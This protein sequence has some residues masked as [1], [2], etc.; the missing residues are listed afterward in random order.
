[1]E[2][3]FSTLVAISIYI[4]L[5]VII[6]ASINDFTSAAIACYSTLFPVAAATYVYLHWIR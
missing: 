5:R 2:I 3:I 4:I 6:Y 1:M